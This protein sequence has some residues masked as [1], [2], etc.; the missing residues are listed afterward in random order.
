[1]KSEKLIPQTL[2]ASIGTSGDTRY[3][4][5]CGRAPEPTSQRRCTG[6]QFEGN[7]EQNQANLG[8]QLLVDV[9]VSGM[10]KRQATRDRVLAEP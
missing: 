10:S 4:G 9:A 6:D 8:G 7:F 3:C 2:H 5:V 1:M